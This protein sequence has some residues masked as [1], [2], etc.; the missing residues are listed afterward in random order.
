VINPP[1]R[2]LFWTGADDSSLYSCTRNY[3]AGSA[4]SA[5]AHNH[6]LYWPNEY[7]RFALINTFSRLRMCP[8]LLASGAGSSTSNVQ[9]R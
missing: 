4:Y 5:K 2:Q 9:R 3:R 1:H 8:S 7:R 6:S